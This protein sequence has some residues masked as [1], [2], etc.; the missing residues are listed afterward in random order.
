MDFPE[1][2]R[3]LFGLGHETAAMKLGLANVTRLLELLGNPHTAYRKIQIAGTN[4]KGSVAAMLSGICRA[5]SVRAG[6]YTSPHLVS[7]TER[8][9]TGDEEISQAEFARHATVVR[10]AAESVYAETGA[11]PTFFEQVTAIALVAFKE[12]GVELAILETGLGG[13]LDATTA[14]EAETAVLTPIGLDHQDYL[15]T[16]L[17]EIAAEKAAII[18]PS[19][20]CVSAPQRDEA[21]VV[22]EERARKC[23]VAV[24]VARGEIDEHEACDMGRMV[25]SLRT[26]RATY[27]RVRLALRGRHQISN[28]L[29]AA[30]AAELLGER[31]ARITTDAIKTG[32]EHATHPGR[33]ELLAATAARPALLL[34]GAHN[35]DGALAL[36]GF[37]REFVTQ[38]LTIVFALMSDKDFRG[39]ATTLFPLASRVVLTRVDNPRAVAPAAMVEALEDAHKS[40]V[41][42]AENVAA[43][44]AEAFRITSRGGLVCVTGSL[45][46]VGEVKGLL[47]ETSAF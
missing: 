2:L 27:E 6:L 4:G 34:D 20:L 40:N 45:Y 7:I 13:R 10:R 12:A 5:A 14:A 22:I 1:S 33:L 25:V 23:D 24:R 31:D 18:R 44:L 38:P 9:R 37:L 35:A 41:Y 11:R 15:G 16:T 46:L 32:L 29:L 39:I 30:T 21:A 3:Y 17:A 19:S 28:A 47:R 8:I 43:A 26:R 42:V 36:A